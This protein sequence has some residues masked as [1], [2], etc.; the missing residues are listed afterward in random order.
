MKGHTVIPRT[1]NTP[2]HRDIEFEAEYNRTNLFVIETAER[3]PIFVSTVIWMSI[4]FVILLHISHKWGVYRS[5]GRINL[6]KL[7]AVQYFFYLVAVV[8]IVFHIPLTSHVQCIL[9]TKTNQ[10]IDSPVISR[11]YNWNC[12]SV[13]FLCASIQCIPFLI[14][15]EWIETSKTMWW[16]GKGLF[17]STYS[18]L[19]L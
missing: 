16:K 13:N 17:Y 18:Q 5:G 4:L 14:H 6:V 11:I 15:K 7:G 9:K 3:R 8:S 2:Y 10:C 19:N 12:M 1:H